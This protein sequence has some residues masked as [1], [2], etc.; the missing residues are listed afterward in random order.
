VSDVIA[1]RFVPYGRH[2]GR[3]LRIASWF[4]APNAA[5]NSSFVCAADGCHAALQSVGAGGETEASS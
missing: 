2:R 5:L 3:P 1:Q 4:L